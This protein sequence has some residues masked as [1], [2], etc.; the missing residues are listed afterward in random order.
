[1]QYRPVQKIGAP[2]HTHTH[3]HTVTVSHSLTVS[4]SVDRGGATHT[5]SHSVT[6]TLTRTHS[7][8]TVR[9]RTTEGQVAIAEDGLSLMVHSLLGD[10]THRV[11][12]LV[13]ARIIDIKHATAAAACDEHPMRVVPDVGNDAVARSN[14]GANGRLTGMLNALEGRLTKLVHGGPAETTRMGK[15][16]RPKSPPGQHQ[17]TTRCRSHPRTHHGRPTTS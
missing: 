5:E 16:N 3:T 10:V 1:M 2:T 14:A 4:H 8:N 6:H 11:R 7:V 12:S 17:R 13:E 9:A 15:R